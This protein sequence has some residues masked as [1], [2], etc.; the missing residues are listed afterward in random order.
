MEFYKER[1]IEGAARACA[2]DGRQRPSRRGTASI[3]AGQQ[4]RRPHQRV[5][6][7]EEELDRLRRCG[8]GGVR[9]SPLPRLIQE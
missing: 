3:H 5:R 4:E 9:R 2:A 6:L 8:Q 1:L 7:D